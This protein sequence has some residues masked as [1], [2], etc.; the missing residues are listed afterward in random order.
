MDIILKVFQQQWHFLLMGAIIVGI[1]FIVK[2]AM[3]QKYNDFCKGALVLTS[4]LYAILAI[5]FHQQDHFLLIPIIVLCCELF[6]YTITGKVVAVLFADFLLILVLNAAPIDKS[7]ELVLFIVL[8]L[9]TAV[10]IGLLMDRHIRKV[11]AEKKA[12]RLERENGE[13]FVAEE[14]LEN[15][16]DDLDEI[17]PV[18]S[19]LDEVK[20]NRDDI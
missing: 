18:Q 16:M 12:K 8:Q 7:L 15:D 4:V 14:P 20:E 3:P 1:T 2:K 10:G 17:D 6:G 13:T 11:Q 19:I 9:I 5:L